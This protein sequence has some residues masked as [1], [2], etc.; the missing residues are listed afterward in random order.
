MFIPDTL[1]SCMIESDVSSY[2]QTSSSGQDEFHPFIEALLPFVKSFSYSWFNLQAAKR[3]YYKKHEKRMSLEE[4]RH[5][6]DEL[7]NEKAEVKQKWAS[8]LLGKLRKDITQECREDFVQSITGKRK[9]ICVL[10]NP[11]Q[12]GKMRRIDCLR[13]ADKVWRLDLVMV[14]LFKA[15]PLESTDGERL[16][17]NPEC[18]HPTL[19]VN[20]YHINVSVRELDLYLAN[21]INTHDVFQNTHSPKSSSSP[22]SSL[23]LYERNEQGNLNNNRISTSRN[24]SSV[25]KKEEILH[26]HKQK[27]YHNP[28]NGVVCNDI[29]L[30]TGVFS[31]KELWKLSKASILDETANEII[32]ANIN[33]IKMEN[34]CNTYECSAYQ[35]PAA[36]NNLATANSAVIGSSDARTPIGSSMVVS[37]GY[38]IDFVDPRSMHLSTSPLLRENVGPCKSDLCIS[39][40]N[41]SAAGNHCSFSVILRPNENTSSNENNHSSDISLQRFTPSNNRSFISMNHMRSNEVFIQQSSGTTLVSNSV[42]PSDLYYQQHSS[43]NTNSEVT[44]SSTA[45]QHHQVHRQQQ[46]HQDM[47]DYATYVHETVPNA[48]TSNIT[49]SDDINSTDSVTLRN[50]KLTSA[51]YQQTHSFMLPP[52]PL[53]PMARP[54]AIIRSTGDLTIINSPPISITPPQNTQTPEQHANDNSHDLETLTKHSTKTI[55]SSASVNEVH[56]NTSSNISEVIT[57]TA[58]SSTVCTSASNC[59]SSNDIIVATI[60]PPPPCPLSPQM[61]IDIARCKSLTRISSQSYPG[62]NGRDYFNHFHAQT[63]PLLGYSSSIPS[64]SGVISP[65]NLSLYSTPSVGGTTT[66]HR[67]TPR[68]RWNP[69]FL[70]DDEFNLMSHTIASTNPETS[71]VILMED[72]SGRF[73]D[74][75]ATTRDYVA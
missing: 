11:D 62:S 47:P 3:K 48:A 42:S 6:K 57:S 53:P 2:L 64:M 63:T 65:T 46:P 13:Q 23:I 66:I 32:Q 39:P 12:K 51:N 22:T 8:R 7:Q 58:S 10:S 20:P 26:E 31:S 70:M 33:A 37:S 5:C 71:S 29:I 34:T 75:Y 49:S 54:V 14:I 56:S 73:N 24:N 55:V 28:Y 1:R 67:T 69:S 4:E 40:A 60:S 30:A 16:E 21:F 52:P 35:L 50:S 17:K 15:I 61:H 44:D 27:G 74:D 18:S 38:S 43:P 9:S 72:S 59:S 36:Q 45:H 19:C 68:P 41:H 25:S